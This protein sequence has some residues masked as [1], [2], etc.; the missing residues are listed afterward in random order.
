MTSVTEYKCNICDK[1]FHLKSRLKSHFVVHSEERTVTICPYDKCHKEYFYKKNLEYHIR[2]CHL[3][4]KVYC[5]ICSEGFKN[6]KNLISHIEE[7][8]NEKKRKSTN[9]IQRKKRKDT[10]MPKRSVI[11][12]LI[13]CKFPHSLEKQ[14]IERETTIKISE[15]PNKSSN[16]AQVE[17][18]VP[19]ERM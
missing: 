15:S 7:V 5:D 18:V 9:K 17:Q 1:L 19:Y 11:S 6:K 13:E 12:R 14:L 8:H 16:D 4:E 10:G 3:G 2:I